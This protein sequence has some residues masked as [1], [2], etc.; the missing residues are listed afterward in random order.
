MTGKGKNRKRLWLV[1]AIFCFFLLILSIFVV[2][3]NWDYQSIPSDHLIGNKTSNVKALKEKGFPFSFL[4][5]SDTHNSN[6]G[7][8]LLKA[9]MMEKD[10][11]FLIHVGDFVNGPN[12]WEHRFFLTNM[13]VDIKPSFPIFLAPGNHD[14]DYISSRKGQNAQRVTPEIYES[15]YGARN[16]NFLF[17]DCLFILCEIDP[18]NLTG[19]LH[20]LRETL[21]PKGVG[22][23][24]IFIFL[25]YPPERLVKYKGGSGLPDE[26][27]FFR[28]VESYK[29]TACFF[30]HYHGYR[31][32]HTKGVQMVVLGGGGGRLKSW[33][34]D[35]GKFHH[36]LKINVNE[37]LITEDMVV[38]PGEAWNF[39]RTFK[40][41]TFVHLFPIIE[42]RVWILYVGLLFFL[43]WGIYSVIMPFR[44]R[45]KHKKYEGR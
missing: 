41:W 7:E 9:A 42:N 6:T 27:E 21:S 5:M 30:G 18:R 39:R 10:I 25:H 16:F 24:Y 28:L 40:K 20:Y 13:S 38:F 2:K 15:F 31:R 1:S 34:S 19:Y 22:R 12:L 32:M 29:V 43:F 17:N 35:W 33:Q 37:D 26:E 45:E 11:S 8:A 44:H 23:K 3:F 36:L 4:I 14:I